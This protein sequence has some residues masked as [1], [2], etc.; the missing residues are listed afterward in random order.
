MCHQTGKTNL[1]KHLTMRNI[2]G[3]I[4]RYAKVL[5]RCVYLAKDVKQCTTNLQCQFIFSKRFITGGLVASKQLALQFH[6]PTT[7][8]ALV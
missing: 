6:D 2:L 8:V 4:L 5:S 1:G 7:V 3:T